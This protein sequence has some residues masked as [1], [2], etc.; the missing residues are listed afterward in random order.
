MRTGVALLCLLAVLA[1]VNAARRFEFTEAG[2]SFEQYKRDFNKNYDDDCDENERHKMLFYTHLEQI[3]THNNRQDTTWKAGVNKYTDLCNGDR[4]RYLGSNIAIVEKMK[5]LREPA[6]E[7]DM[8]GDLPT[9]VDW[10]NNNPSIITAVKDQG[11]CGSCWAHAATEQVES[12]LVLNNPSTPLVALS[13][14]NLVDCVQNPDDCGGTGGCGGATAELG[15]AYVEG[16]KGMASEADYPYTGADGTCDESAAKAAHL[17]NYVTL[18]SNNYTA[19]VWAVATVGPMA[20]NVAASPWFSY[21]SGVFDG[22][23]FDDVDVNHVVQL[24]GYGT[25]SSQGDYWTV[26]NS[27]GADWGESGYIRVQK[28]SDGDPSK[29]CGNDPTPGDGTGCNG[30]P[31]S[32]SVCGSCGIWYDSSY[33]L[34]VKPVS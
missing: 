27:W 11:G 34:G 32:I 31:S 26:R 1:A 23:T 10:R 33:P 14:Q 9:A 28:H 21:S 19:L 15:F 25:D 6:P 16:G 8:S 18:P 5:A 17:D 7:L 13:R 20:V 24:V 22:C 2:Y 12:F 29:W 3:I 30:G 4:A